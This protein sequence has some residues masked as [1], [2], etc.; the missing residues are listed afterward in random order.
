MSFIVGFTET[1][2]KKYNQKYG[3][4]AIN[5]RTLLLDDKT[6]AQSNKNDVPSHNSYLEANWE[7]E[8]LPP[9]F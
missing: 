9:D 4:L 2:R 3:T 5:S 8:K 6:E 7:P 1:R